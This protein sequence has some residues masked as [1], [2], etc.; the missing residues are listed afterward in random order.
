[1]KIL[2]VE[3]ANVGDAMLRVSELKKGTNFKRTN[4]G[5][6]SFLRR[7]A[8]RLHMNHSVLNSVVKFLVFRIG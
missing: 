2:I 3:F 7:K 1:M 6:Y 8:S 5:H 4:F